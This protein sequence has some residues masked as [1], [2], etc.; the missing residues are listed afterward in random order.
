MKRTFELMV[1]LISTRKLFFEIFENGQQG[2]LLLKEDVKSSPAK[3]MRLAKKRDI[4][5]IIDSP[6]WF[7]MLS[8]GRAFFVR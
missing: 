1:T 5:D 8:S 3:K 2:R 7:E 6:A 4:P